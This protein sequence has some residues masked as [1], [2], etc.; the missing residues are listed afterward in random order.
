MGE[1]FLAKTGELAGFEKRC[2]VKKIL[3]S[4]AVDQ[5]FIGRFI[6]EAQVAIK[7][8]HANIAA[9]FEVGRVEGE[10]FLVLEYVEGR[11]LRKVLASLSDRGVR[12]PIDI[13]LWIVRDIASGLAYAHRKLDDDGSPLDVVHC[14]ISPPNVVLSY[15][16][17]VKLIDFGIAKSAVRVSQSN[18]SIGF[19]KFGYMA[20]EQL[21]RGA[22]V[23][24]RT[25][26]Y[27]TGVIL[28]ELLTGEKLFTFPDGADYR[29][30]AQTV[31]Q[32]QHPLPSER[33]PALAPFDQLVKRA[34]SP[35]PARRFATAE[36]LR[37]AI[38]SALVQVNPTMTADRLGTYMRETFAAER[39]SE[40]EV[41]K[42]VTELDLTD[43]AEEMTGPQTQ[44][45][46]FARADT[47]GQPREDGG[48][49]GLPGLPPAPPPIPSAVSEAAATPVRRPA[50]VPTPNRRLTDDV[51]E[52]E[53]T[54]AMDPPPRP[55]ATPPRE[56]SGTMIVDTSPPPRARS[57]RRAIFIVTP[58]LLGVILTI[59]LVKSFAH[60][61]EARPDA[62][63]AFVV[64]PIER[65]VP[66][67]ARASPD[68][69]PATAALTP[70]AS[71]RRPIHRPT[72]RDAAPA[73]V[74]VP[75]G[76][77]RDAIKT[78]FQALRKTYDAFSKQYGNRFES[79]WTEIHE[80][81]NFGSGDAQLVELDHRI[82]EL[83]SKMDRVV[84]GKDP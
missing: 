13:A 44:T 49:P 65:V 78:R 38:Q 62:A 73:T 77:D 30:I 51:D 10:Y 74:V 64:T 81:L 75:R 23:D 16:G 5:D 55:R 70:D 66:D 47:H 18:P 69:A 22:E 61:P 57:L 32:G 6:D 8:N 33:D 46:T 2:V 72:A 83:E 68:A 14:D 76:P 7:L 48:P 29:T 84:R 39:A 59:V 34:V 11:D 58:F 1:I 82:K 3:P 50:S 63:P 40:S 37:D 26:L 71:P 53:P 79:E 54:F 28:Y 80:L 12:L 52:D 20:P 45:V 21:I 67:A 24:R 27:A 35:E 9:V 36:E 42:K 60:T 41:L 25:D 43:F 56:P 31:A 17:E 15:E 4:L 19:G